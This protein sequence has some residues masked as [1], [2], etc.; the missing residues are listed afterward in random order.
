[1]TGLLG[2][3]CD[4]N[5]FSPENL[6]IIAEHVNFFKEN[7]EKILRAE[8]YWLTPPENFEKKRGWLALQLSDPVTD[9]HF[10]YIFHNICDGDFKRIFHPQGLDP[11]Q[12]Y[13]FYEKFPAETKLSPGFSGRE[14][15]RKGITAQFPYDQLEGFRGK[16]FVIEPVR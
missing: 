6:R 7:R 13:W 5:S 1:M 10:L 16:L 14:L 9:T 3:S 4:L 8:P 12:L 2:F 11:A 15:Q